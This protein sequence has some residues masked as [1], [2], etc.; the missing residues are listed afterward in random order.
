MSSASSD[1]TDIVSGTSSIVS[2]EANVINASPAVKM[3]ECS[4]LS[5]KALSSKVSVTNDTFGECIPLNAQLFIIFQALHVLITYVTVLTLNCQMETSWVM[6]QHAY[7]ITLTFARVAQRDWD[8]I[9]T[10]TNVTLTT[11][12]AIMMPIAVPLI[13]HGIHLLKVK[14]VMEMEMINAIAHNVVPSNILTS[15]KTVLTTYVIAPTV[16]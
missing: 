16:K 8:I 9:S 5:I 2:T 10:L 13:K 11:V 15:T 1:I 7:L 12:I 4:A 3:L 14:Y 6:L